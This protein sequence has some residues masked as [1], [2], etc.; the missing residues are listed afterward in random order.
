M[1]VKT[2]QCYVTYFHTITNCLF[3]FLA[4]PGKGKETHPL[5]S[6]QCAC[7]CAH[8]SVFPFPPRSR[9]WFLL[10]YPEFYHLLTSS[11]S[12]NMSGKYKFYSLSTGASFLAPMSQFWDSL[13][14]FPGFE[15]S[16][17]GTSDFPLAFQSDSIDLWVSLAWLSSSA[18]SHIGH[19]TSQ[20]N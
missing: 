2:Y 14:V 17:P 18:Y 7:T 6:A 19:W 5:A 4:L 1:F 16:S 10:C 9:V 12:S 15:F 3:P 11:W 13:G 20:S 8:T